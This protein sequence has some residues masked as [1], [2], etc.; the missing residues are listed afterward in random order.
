MP[1]CCSQLR[2]KYAVLREQ[3]H[4]R[5]VTQFEGIDREKHIYTSTTNSVTVEIAS[6][7]PNVVY[8]LIKY[9]GKLPNKSTLSL[10]YC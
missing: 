4:V 1:S 5:T 8:F 2:Y 10:C 9:Q 6:K 3:T 7:K